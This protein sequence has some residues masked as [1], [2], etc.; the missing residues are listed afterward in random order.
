MV[1]S[2]DLGSHILLPQSAVSFLAIKGKKLPMSGC[3]WQRDIQPR[4]RRDSC[5]QMGGWGCW[6]PGSMSTSLQW[7]GAGLAAKSP[8]SRMLNEKTGEVTLGKQATCITIVWSQLQKG[9][10]CVCMFAH[11]IS[12]KD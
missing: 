6:D 10:P 11:G 12:D 1:W 2:W 3:C 8:F 4:S 9:K 7:M 5:K